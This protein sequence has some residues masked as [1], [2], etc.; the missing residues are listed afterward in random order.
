MSRISVDVSSARIPVLQVGYQGE[1]EVTDVLFDISSWITEFGEGVAQLRVKR[2]G[3]S[4]EESYVLSLTITDGIAVWTVSD[5]DTF[6]K[7]NGKVQLSYLVG[8]IVKKAVI[9]PYKVGK[10]IVGAD[11]PVDP[12]DS[13]IERSKAWAIGETLDG[14]AVPETDETYQNN[15]KYYA[16]QADILGSA[17]VVLAT[18]QV[19]LATAKANAAAASETNAA[20]SEAAVN[21]VS[22]QLTTRMSAIETE[23]S[24][25][26]A[27]MDTFTSLPEGSTSGNAE[28]ADIRVGAAGTTYDTAGNAVR[29]QIGELK[30]D[31]NNMSV[32]METFGFYSAF[33]ACGLWKGDNVSSEKYRATSQSVMVFDRDINIK[34]AS[35]YRI[36]FNLFVDG[37]Y[38]S[39]SAWFEGTYPLP[40]GTVFKIVIAKTSATEDTTSTA[41]VPTFVNA[42]KFESANGYSLAKHENGYNNIFNLDYISARYIGRYTR[43]GIHNGAIYT[44]QHWRVSN[45]DIISTERDLL[46]KVKENGFRFNVTLYDENGSV[47]PSIGWTT[48]EHTI[49]KGSRFRLQI[50]RV[51]ENESEYADVDEFANA[52]VVNSC[53]SDVA[54]SVSETILSTQ[55]NLV[56]GTFD[57]GQLNSTDSKRARTKYIY[58]DKP[59]EFSVTPN[60]DYYWLVKGSAVIDGILQ[61][62]EQYV[63][64]W[65]HT[66]Q[67]LILQKGVYVLIVANGSTYDTSI[68]YDLSNPS[69][70]FSFTSFSLA[71]CVNLLMNRYDNETLTSKYAVDLPNYWEEYMETKLPSII[72]QVRE[73]SMTGDSFVFFTDYHIEY[74]SGKSH[75]LMNRIL[76]NTPINKVVFGGDVLNGSTTK[77]E[78]HAKYQEFAQRFRKL[79]MFG[80]RGNHEYNLNDGGSESVKFTENEIYN[81]IIKLCEDKITSTG[82]MYYYVDNQ[83]QKIRY[84]FLDTRNLSGYD[85]YPIDDTQLVWL[86]ATLAELTSEWNVVIFTHQFFYYNSAGSSWHI[87]SLGEQIENAIQNSN[88]V[89]TIC[90]IISGHTHKDYSE[91]K[92]GVAYIATTWDG[93]YADSSRELGTTTELAFDVFTID[94]LAKTIKATRIGYGEDR[95]WTYGS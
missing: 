69:I 87:N 55:S 39:E 24:V 74:N 52:L 19:T 35:G 34:I 21:G 7:G 53:L 5:T 50:A 36:R 12:F 16:E 8:N 46:V 41:D 58:V 70:E 76:N 95:V 3:N 11:N 82:K 80:I 10:S 49:I 23:Q 57:N 75:L 91:M 62:V 14:N 84:I 90:A 65:N 71:D 38:S 64:S 43:A 15:A 86:S 81:Y 61:D 94:T 67:K 28:L 88:T 29:G 66:S 32:G 26:S 83:P 6:N 40:K 13:W 73:S 18:E 56:K 4:E 20:A 77:A 9:Y 48:S 54:N 17:Q 78:S 72:S 51:T 27:R 63:P 45:T 30:S 25:Q 2:P 42:I 60:S 44:P 22:T 68:N 33:N 59:T 92:N 37:V 79:P 47:I 93:Y 1:N 31:L 89:A 85:D